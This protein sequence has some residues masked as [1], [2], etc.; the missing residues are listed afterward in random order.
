MELEIF[1][2]TASRLKEQR[3]KKGISH[4]TLA[5]K[6]QSKYEI[7]ISVDSLKFYE[8]TSSS[9]DRRGKCAGMRLEYLRCLADF[10]GVSA[11]YLLGLSN[12]PTIDVDIKAAEQLTGLS[13]AAILKLKEWHLDKSESTNHGPQFIE[14]LSEMVTT[15]NFEDFLNDITH[16]LLLTNC[17]DRR[18]VSQKDFDETTNIVHRQQLD[19]MEYIQ[20]NAPS[21]FATAFLALKSNLAPDDI[22]NFYLQSAK[23]NISYAIK[24]VNEHIYAK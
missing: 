21:A 22:A 8:I 7:K 4:A 24:E 20:Q 12:S 23:D 5:E 9:S 14:I 10:Y 13:T 16:Y 19:T 6:L 18:Y 3:Q 11:D 15:Y 1:D 2:I 17:H